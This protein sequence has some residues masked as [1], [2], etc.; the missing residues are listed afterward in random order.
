LGRRQW[1]HDDAPGQQ[2]TSGWDVS[3]SANSCVTS[4]SRWHRAL[5]IFNRTGF[6]STPNSS[7][8]DVEDVV[9][10]LHFIHDATAQG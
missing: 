2:C 8:A 10:A 9:L 3:I 4:L 5:M 6:A 7:A 1:S